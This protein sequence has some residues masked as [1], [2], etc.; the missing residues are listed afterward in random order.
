MRNLL[1]FILMTSTLL[2]S[3]CSA[4]QTLP[5]VWQTPGIFPEQ[6]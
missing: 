3:A 6:E 1:L 5:P 2:L 4:Y